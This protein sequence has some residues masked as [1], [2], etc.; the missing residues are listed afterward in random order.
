MT[1]ENEY[2]STIPAQVLGG[3]WFGGR[4]KSSETLLFQGPGPA[5]N[6]K[7]LTRG[8]TEKEK[9]IILDI[10][11]KLRAKIAQ[12]TEKRGSPG[13]QPGASNMKKMVSCLY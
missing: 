11:N 7:P 1:Q 12:G 3:S 4:A 2:T 10:H 13:P 5:C 6:G 8:V 9:E